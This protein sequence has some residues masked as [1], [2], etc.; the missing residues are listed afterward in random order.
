VKISYYLLIEGEDLPKVNRFSAKTLDSEK[1]VPWADRHF[2]KAVLD[3]T[4]YPAA[5]LVAIADNGKKREIRAWARPEHS[6]S[7]GAAIWKCT[8]EQKLI[9]AIVGQHEFWLSQQNQ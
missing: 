1:A 9:D 4:Y 2:F 3:Y 6:N 8:P 5:T 7:A